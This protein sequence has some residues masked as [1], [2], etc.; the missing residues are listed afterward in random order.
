MVINSS[1]VDLRD[2]VQ[3]Y[4]E[5][6]QYEVLEAMS[7]A[8]DEVAKESAKKIKANAPRGKTNT[9]Y[10]GW[11][12]TIEKG[13]LSHSSVVYGKS[14]TYQLAHLLEHGHAKRGGGR[15][16]EYVHIK[17]VE[18]WAIDEVVNRTISKMERM[19]Q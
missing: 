19:T 4:I 5:D 1:K 2:V 9:Y 18:E 13:R 14:G 3:E 10:K 7:E 16:N 11:T 17:P 8:I 6:Q 12:Y 15:T